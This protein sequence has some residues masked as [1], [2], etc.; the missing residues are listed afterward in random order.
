M[1]NNFCII[2]WISMTSDNAGLVRPCCKFAEK[3]VQGEYQTPNL[4]DHSYEDI[5]NGPEMQA[6]RQAFLDSK[7]IPEC[8]S[9]WKEEAAGVFSN[10]QQY[11]TS[12]MP[13]INPNDYSTTYAKPPRVIDLKLSNVCNFKCRMCDF[14][15]SSLILKED[16]AF[17][18][19]D[20]SDESYYLSN[21][22][23]DT[24][25]EDY[26]FNKIVPNL[27][28]IEFTGGEPFVSP[29]AKKIIDILS[30]SEYA[31]NIMINITTNG[32]KVNT[33]ILSQLEKF[34]SVRIGL[35]IDDIGPRAEYQR[36]GTIWETVSHNC[37]FFNDNKK[38]YV[39]LHPTINNYSIWNFDKTLEWARENDLNVVTNILHG[40]T[41]LCIKNLSAYSKSKVYE[42]HKDNKAMVSILSYMMQDGADL[43]EDFIRE[44]EWI[45]SIRNE[46]FKEVFPDWSEIIYASL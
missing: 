10:R 4:K 1:K 36:K 27:L 40:P 2:P 5:W 23:L 25:N 17:R 45:D 20:I 14:S 26:F 39:N 16:K 38:F 8:S 42:K 11:N 29:E 9:C 21:K 33:S 30:Q 37:K 35:S 22:I 44:T 31:A 18:G 6:I 41:R 3:D 34:K 24:K 46:S 15:Y 12:Y 7:K 13:Q 28:Q 19:Y 43:T 32:S